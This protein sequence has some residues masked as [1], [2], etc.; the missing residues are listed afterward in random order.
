MNSLTI[1]QVVW[2]CVQLPF[3]VGSITFGTPVRLGPTDGMSDGFYAVGPLGDRVVFGLHP[4]MVASGRIGGRPHQVYP[5]TEATMSSSDGE[6]WK[7]TPPSCAGVVAHDRRYTLAAYPSEC[8]DASHPSV[9]TSLTTFG[10]FA[11][12]ASPTTTNSTVFTAT[13]ATVLSYSN[14]GHPLQCSPAADRTSTRIRGLPPLAV[15]CSVGGLRFSGAAALNLGP[16]GEHRYLATVLGELAAGGRGNIAIMAVGSAD[17]ITWD[18][19][20]TIAPHMNSAEGGPNE[21]DL[22]YLP[23]NNRILAMF[24]V[25]A[26]AVAN[27]VQNYARSVSSDRGAT[28]SKPA[29]VPNVGCARPRLLQ[30]GSTMIMAGGL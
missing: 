26:G 29:L 21:M 14:D 12:I 24:R 22:A 19:L 27:C 6:R 30:M 13:G 9:C 20:S 1:A 15:C 7:P 28:W 2:G 8:S 23:D 11:D 5:F 16:G 25:C 3:V 17:G 18:Y 4:K 10:N